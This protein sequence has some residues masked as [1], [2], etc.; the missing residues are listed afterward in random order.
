MNLQMKRIL[1][2]AEN[3]IL[4]EKSDPFARG[5]VLAHVRNGIANIN[6]NGEDE[7]YDASPYQEERL[8]PNGTPYH[9]TVYKNVKRP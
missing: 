3:Y 9:V 2:G 1:V 6:Q 8:L 4:S 5:R 7:F